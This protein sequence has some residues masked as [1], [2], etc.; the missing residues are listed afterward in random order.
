MVE[1]YATVE[2]YIASFN[3]ETQAV[4][5][6]VRRVVT[7]AVPGATESI[8]YQMPTIAIGGERVLHFAG[9]TSH[10]SVYPVPAGDG[11]FEQE[12]ARYRSSKGTLKF[13]L[14]KPI[15]YGLIRRVAELLAAQRQPAAEQ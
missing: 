5:R 14:S 1:K 3:A 11:D 15:P 9:W 13:P 2:D 4:L 7:D 6:E 10:I 12:I 8:S